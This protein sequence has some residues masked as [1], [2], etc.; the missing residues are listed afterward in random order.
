MFD[1]AGRVVER[2]VLPRGARLIGF[3][4]GVVYLSRSDDDGLLYLQKYR[5]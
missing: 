1:G 5:Y 2:V 4:K 3:G